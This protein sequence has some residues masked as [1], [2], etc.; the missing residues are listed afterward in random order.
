MN[1]YIQTRSVTKDYQFLGNSP[2][3][4]WW[5][6]YKD[7]TSFEH[8]TIIVEGDIAKQWRV[9]LSG[10]SS[11]RLDKVNTPIRYTFIL[12]DTQPIHDSDLAQFLG[13]IQAWTKAI[14]DSESKDK[15]KNRLDTLFS[16]DDINAYFSNSDQA[17]A[18]IESKFKQWLSGFT[19]TDVELAEGMQLN[20]YIGSLEQS[21]S[22]FF[23][24]C[25]SILK[26]NAEFSQAALHLNYIESK[27]ELESTQLVEEEYKFRFTL[28]V[29][30]EEVNFSEINL[31]KKTTQ[32][33]KVQQL[34]TS[35]S[36][37]PK[38][39]LY[40]LVGIIVI[41]LVILFI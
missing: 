30:A 2:M 10:M 19:F 11:S 22:A 16:V 4:S 28:L 26:M 40:I 34:S 32:A 36:K 31:K 21:Q 27:I 41:I 23:Q 39:I 1:I 20:S 3:N 9:Y 7:Y 15:L 35:K 29:E 18:Q 8:A 12:E 24:R 33:E 13:L 37:F 17:K 25:K 14:C 38:N 6:A 5:M